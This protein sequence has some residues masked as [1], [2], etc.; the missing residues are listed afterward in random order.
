MNDLLRIAD[1]LGADNLADS[2][3]KALQRMLGARSLTRTLSEAEVD[4]LRNEI[5]QFTVR[6][7]KRVLNE[8]IDREPEAYRD[9]RGRLCRFPRHKPKVYPSRR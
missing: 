6:R 9:H 1:M 2:T 7:T 3:L 8:L 5:R 4:Q